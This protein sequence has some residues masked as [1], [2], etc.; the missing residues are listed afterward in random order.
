MY[1]F[2]S[3]QKNGHSAK[4]IVGQNGQKIAFGGLNF[5]VRKGRVMI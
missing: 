3:K 1:W 4:A 5:K 2:S